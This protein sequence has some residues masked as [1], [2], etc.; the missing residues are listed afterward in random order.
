ML[1]TDRQVTPGRN[2]Q[3]DLGRMRNAPL[4]PVA[5]TYGLRPRRYPSVWRRVSRAASDWRALAYSPALRA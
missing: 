1:S 2:P 5:V 4:C 3:V